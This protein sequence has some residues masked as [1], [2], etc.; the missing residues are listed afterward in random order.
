M[1]IRLSNFLS[2]RLWSTNLTRYAGTEVDLTAAVN[3]LTS[4]M[5]L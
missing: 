5:A 2:D 4:I 3:V 1:G